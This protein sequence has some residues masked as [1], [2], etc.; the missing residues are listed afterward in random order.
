MGN[1]PYGQP[2]SGKID[3]LQMFDFP[4]PASFVLDMYLAVKPLCAEYAVSDMNEDCEVNVEDFVYLAVQWL[5]CGR[6]P[7]CL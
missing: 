1:L 4:L 2:Y 5:E 6:V 7:D 3:D